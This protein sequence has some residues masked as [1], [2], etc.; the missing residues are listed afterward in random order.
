MRL[1]EFRLVLLCSFMKAVNE[2]FTEFCV[3]VRSSV[4]D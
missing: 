1:N 4:T 3:I 2:A